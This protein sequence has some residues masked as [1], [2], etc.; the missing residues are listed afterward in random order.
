MRQ[1]IA[2]AFPYDP[3]NPLPVEARRPFPNFVVYIDSNWGGSSNYNAFNTKLEHRGRGSLLTFAYT[4]AKS[5]DSKSAAAGIGAQ[6]VQRLAG[7]PQQ[8]RSGARSRAVGLRRRSSTGRELRLQPAVRQ[9]RALCWRCDGRQERDRRRLAGERHLHLAERIPDHDSGRGSRRIE[10]HVRFQ[11]RRHRRRSPTSA[12]RPSS[13]GSTRPP[14]RSQDSGSSATQGATSC[15][16]PASTTSIS[17]C[18]RTSSSATTCGCSSGSSRSISSTTRSST[19]SDSNVSS[20]TF[21][22][23]NSARSGRINQLGLKFPF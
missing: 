13:T 19:A 22:V 18:S 4:W 17:R 7:I 3:A 1:N 2:Q 10:R 16:A 20:A 21:G 15:A 23:L 14:S 11:S 9:R 6:R 8:S 12:T 5:T